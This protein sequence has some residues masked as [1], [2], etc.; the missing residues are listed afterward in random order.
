MLNKCGIYIFSA[1]INKNI[2]NVRYI[3]NELI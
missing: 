3:N 1:Q 2:E